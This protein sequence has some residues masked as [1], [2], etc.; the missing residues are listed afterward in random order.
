MC[1]VL[2]H[3]ATVLASSWNAV[4]EVKSE[5]KNHFYVAEHKKKFLL[6]R[7]CY[8]LCPRL[9]EKIIRKRKKK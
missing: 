6:K 5:I 4:L 7:F 3:N 2:Y 1:Y 9:L 8:Y